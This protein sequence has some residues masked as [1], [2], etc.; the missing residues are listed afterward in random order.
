MSIAA[1][2]TL[3]VRTAGNLVEIPSYGYLRA[4]FQDLMQGLQVYRLWWDV[5]DEDRTGDQSVWGLK[6]EF[7]E[8]VNVELF[9]INTNVMHEVMADTDDPL[10]MPIPLEGC[11]IP[12]EAA[13]PDELAEYEQIAGACIAMARLGCSD[14]LA[15]GDGPE[16]DPDDPEWSPYRVG[17]VDSPFFY[18]PELTWMESGVPPSVVD[19]ALAR[20]EAVAPPKAAGL[21]DLIRVSLDLP[22]L[23]H[24]PFLALPGWIYVIEYDFMRWYWTKEDVVDLKNLYRNAE[25]FIERIGAYR[26]WFVSQRESDAH[27]AVLSFLEATR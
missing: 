12:W 13:P 23:A 27:R 3:P 26:L 17:H 5:F 4:R 11:R 2:Q 18:P 19:R 24:N 22:G 9:P 16:V 8:R 15:F 10:A 21:A 1:T 20:I 6:R 25:P 14:D 7:V